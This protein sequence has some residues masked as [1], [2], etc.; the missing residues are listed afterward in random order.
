MPAKRLLLSEDPSSSSKRPRTR[1]SF[2]NL[3][4]TPDD[5]L[6]VAESTTPSRLPSVERK[7]PAGPANPGIIRNRDNGALSRLPP[8]SDALDTFANLRRDCNLSD[9]EAFLKLITTYDVPLSTLNRISTVKLPASFSKVKY[10]D[11]A[12]YVWLDPGVKGSDIC[13]LDTFRSRIPVDIFRRIHADVNKAILQY[14]RM[15]S[16]DNE[17]A[18]SR[19]IASL[20]S[21]IVCLFGSAVVNKPEGLLDAEFTKKGRIEHNFYAFHSVSIVFLE[22]KKN[23]ILGDGRLDVIAQVL[24][25]C[26]ACDYAN[27]KSQHWVPILAI[28][29]DGEKFEFLVYDSGTKSV[30]SSDVITGVVDMKTK[31]SLFLSSV[32]ETTEYLFDY[33]L[34][35]YINGLRSFGHRSELVAEQSRPKKRKSTEK[36]MDAL[37][38]AEHAHSLCREAAELA[39]R[40]MLE[41]AEETAARGIVELKESVLQAPDA[42]MQRL[43]EWD[44]E[45][46]MKA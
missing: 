6:S 45:V 25:E 4:P 9:E 14:G 36:W 8:D 7:V 10:S 37:A 30:Y 35:A 28:L 2:P 29:C 34:M 1:S 39:Q 15:A 41:K 42:K 27:S 19:F 16:H 32:K 21:E 13:L 33:F 20:F 43:S 31:P 40:G 17:E 18:R 3:P 26:A 22:I 38:R 23:Y 44:E 5:L 11:V 24:A 12:P 46:V